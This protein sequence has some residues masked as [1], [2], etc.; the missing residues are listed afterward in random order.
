MESA[1]T[2]K[3]VAESDSVLE[4]EVEVGDAGEEEMGDLFGD[5][6][7]DDDDEV[8]NDEE[9][10]NKKI[11]GVDVDDGSENE[12]N[13][14]DDE[15]EEVEAEEEEIQAAD[16]TLERHPRSHQ[17][18]DNHAYNFPL[19]RFLFVDPTP[20][21]SNVFEEQLKDFI[22]ELNT[23]E[24]FKSSIQFKK[25]QLNN[26]IRWRYAK[27][28][29]NELFKQSN[30]NI[31]EWEDGSMSLKLGN[32][33]FDIKTKKNDD[34]ILAF[35]TP[36]E[37]LLMS[38]MDMDKSIQIL[39]PSMNSKAHQILA[40]TLTKNMKMK[41]SKRINT[42]VTHED[43]E[44]KAR[45]V[46]RAQKEIEKA[47]KRQLMKLQ[48]QEEQSER[49]SNSSQSRFRESHEGYD[50]DIDIGDEYDD[51]DD[52]DDYGSGKNGFV[53]DDEDEVSEIDDDELD[54]AAE[55]LKKVKRD[56]AAKYR[57][58][59]DGDDGEEEEDGD[60][61]DGAV[62]KKKRKIIVDEDED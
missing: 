31:I 49:R 36:G 8:E 58:R 7:D 52:G 60:D 56:G 19:P 32:E 40:S 6:D 57:N 50:D 28:K 47:R 1:V 21:T 38:V 26:T 35:K 44:L 53:V 4:N 5:D 9:V 46:E 23:E 17:P 37:N 29:S 13:S 16:L 42:I 25:L 43:P 11:S 30:A 12:A 3:I 54:K 51:E 34:N 15:D 24:S 10:N 14:D 45:E 41:K 2:D 20:F 61:D 55:R 27:T 22:S 59:D 18:K 33:Y 62:V 48:V 39:P